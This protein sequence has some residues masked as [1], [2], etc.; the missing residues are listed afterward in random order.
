[1]RPYLPNIIS[2]RLFLRRPSSVLLGSDPFCRTQ[3]FHRDPMGGNPGALLDGPNRLGARQG[4]ALVGLGT[5]G[6]VRVAVEPDS[7]RGLGLQNR[8]RIVQRAGGIGTLPSGTTTVVPSGETNGTSLGRFG[9]TTPSGL[10]G[11]IFAFE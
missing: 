11:L 4:R 3:S 9:S 5:S 6:I 10:F 1:M 7:H 2:I 8:S